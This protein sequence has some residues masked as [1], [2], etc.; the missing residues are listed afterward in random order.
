MVRVS[1]VVLTSQN[2]NLE[3]F[4]S[5]KTTKGEIV[6]V[7]VE[8]GSY[9]GTLSFAGVVIYDNIIIVSRD[10]FEDSITGLTAFPPSLEAIS[11]KNHV[12]IIPKGRLLGGGII[13]RY[14]G[15]IENGMSSA[16]NAEKI[17][18]A[19]LENNMDIQSIPPSGLSRFFEVVLTAL[20]PTLVFE[21]FS[22]ELART[23]ESRVAE[24]G[25]KI[26]SARALNDA[27]IKR[28]Q[29]RQRKEQLTNFIEVKREALAEKEAQVDANV[30]KIQELE[31]E[32]AVKQKAI[33]T[34]QLILNMEKY[35]NLESK[36]ADA[37][38]R[39]RECEQGVRD[40]NNL[41]SRWGTT[42]LNVMMQVEA[43]RKLAEWNRKVG[44]IQAAIAI[45]DNSIRQNAR[46]STEVRGV[47]N[48]KGQ[49]ERSNIN[50]NQLV[51]GIQR[52]IDNAR[53]ELVRIKL[54]LREV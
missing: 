26:T 29:L 38:A 40:A 31:Q 2:Q 14:M 23:A 28:H 42:R 9:Q 50:L 32:R 19:L 17:A 34:T 4:R 49:L 24:L 46:L 48:S 18:D 39:K 41:T 35:R 52:E 6:D 15:I 30:R 43:N 27:W 51:R 21:D 8:G 12:H 25:R 36:R 37:F 13:E 44:D 3:G 45:R 20:D 33:D 16:V 47:I 1:D 5:F 54:Q 7:R 11:N 10:S 22:N 53:N